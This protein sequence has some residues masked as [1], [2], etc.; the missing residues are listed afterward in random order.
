MNIKQKSTSTPLSDRTSA[1]VK[2]PVW[3]D[4]A[5]ATPCPFCGKTP[6]LETYPPS[7]S[8]FVC[9]NDECPVLPEGPIKPTLKEA[10]EAWTSRANS[11]AKL[12][13]AEDIDLS[14]YSEMELYGLAKRFTLG[15]VQ[16]EPL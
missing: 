9:R 1:N 2:L 11:W 8:A 3:L 4:K 12:L 6:Y 16:V 5:F 15:V 13:A 7:K 14:E 10:A